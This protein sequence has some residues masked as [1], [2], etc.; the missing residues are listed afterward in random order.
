MS[1]ICCSSGQAK[2]TYTIPSEG[3]LKYRLK[4]QSKWNLISANEPLTSQCNPT[5][6]AGIFYSVSCGID[7]FSCN[8]YCVG[9]ITWLGNNQIQTGNG[10]ATFTGAGVGRNC[11]GNL[12]ITRISP[13]QDP[14]L[15]T[16]K[17]ESGQIYHQQIVTQCPD[18]QQA[19]CVFD[20]KNEQT[21]TVEL[22]QLDLSLLRNI[23]GWPSALP[24]N[25]KSCLE[26]VKL[27]NA[28]FLLG[29]PRIGFIA[30]LNIPVELRGLIPNGVTIPW[31]FDQLLDFSIPLKE[32]CPEPK[33]KIQC[34]GDPKDRSKKCP[35]ET[36]CQLECNGFL[37]CYSKGRLIQSIKL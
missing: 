2:I 21:L 7:G 8:P 23:P 29:E 36:D 13:G 31:L 6:E 14:Y 20:P 30:S 34:E 16:I 37:C 25:F 33:V 28:Q 12:I 24:T 32:G 5:T 10:V 3:G 19:G 11:D 18:V 26:A 17:G 22:P 15:F 9:P 1:K 27:P 4:G 35:P